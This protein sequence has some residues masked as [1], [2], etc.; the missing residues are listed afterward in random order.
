MNKF[1]AKN[2]EGISK[3]AIDF[4]SFGHLLVGYFAFIVLDAIFLVFLN[5]YSFIFAILSVVFGGL[6]W[7]VIENTYLVK[8]D[9]KF[10]N[11]KDSTL[12]SFTDVLIL[13]LGG[14]FARFSLQFNLPT[15]LFIAISF[16]IG[17]I[18]IMS[19]YASKFIDVFKM[20]R[21]EEQLWISYVI[22]YLLLKREEKRIN[23]WTNAK[24]KM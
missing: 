3:A 15:F 14:L 19:L 22:K 5:G 7:E 24:K 6:I 12:N 18:L 13:F 10:G 20:F 11:R 23:S 9:I 4:F 2:K 1:Y 17:N 16:F 21:N 8:K